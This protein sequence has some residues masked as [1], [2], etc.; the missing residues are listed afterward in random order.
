MSGGVSAAFMKYLGTGIDGINLCAV[1]ECFGKL[2][3]DFASL[4]NAFVCSAQI[5][6]ILTISEFTGCAP[7]LVV[8][9]SS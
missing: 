7:R 4:S 8:A 6:P 3:I 2:G 9:V 1:M 5:H